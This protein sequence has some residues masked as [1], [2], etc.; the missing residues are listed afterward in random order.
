M[1]D[2]FTVAT[3]IK[4]TRVIARYAFREIYYCCQLVKRDTVM[5]DHNRV[6]HDFKI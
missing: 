5:Q 6:S 3:N 4:H 1:I 2:N